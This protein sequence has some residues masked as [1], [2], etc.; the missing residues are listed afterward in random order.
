MRRG[1]W[2]LL[3]AAGLF[4]AVGCEEEEGD[5][6]DTVV[7]EGTPP[8]IIHEP[9]AD[10]Q[11]AFVQV[12][13]E[14][15]VTDDTGVSA[16]SLFY[17]QGGQLDWQISYLSPTGEP[18]AYA[19]TLAAT[20]V[21]ATGVD[22]YIRAVDDA[23]PQAEAFSPNGAP[24]EFHHFDV[25]V[26]GETLPFFEDWEDGAD[27]IDL[28]WLHVE[29]GMGDYH[30]EL[31][32]LYASSGGVSVMHKE[33][34]NGVPMFKD[35][36]ISP[37]LEFDGATDMAVNWYELGLYTSDMELHQ[38]Y[39]S[40]GSDDPDLGDFQLVTDL[41]APLEE[42]WAP[43]EVIDITDLVG[44]GGVGYVAFYYEGEYPAD[45]WFVDD[46][47][48]GEP[49]P[50]FVIDEITV[51]P[52][53]FE[54]GD[55]LDITISVTNLALV[56]SEPVTGSL[57]SDDAL[58]VQTGDDVD[59]GAVASGAT[60][61]GDGA[62]ELTIDAEH[63]DNAYLD[64]ALRLTDG[65]HIWDL[66]FEL[67]MGEESYA[68]VD[69]DATT[70]GDVILTVGYGDPDF[71][72]FEV[73]T[74]VE[75]TSQWST[76]LTS[77]ADYLPP[78]VG[79]DRWW[80]KITN[81]G[82]YPTSVS[83]FEI[84]WGGEVFTCEELPATVLAQSEGVVYLPSLP[85]LEVGGAITSPDPVAPGDAAVE[86]TLRVDNVGAVATAGA[87]TGTLTSTDPHVSNITGAGITFGVDPLEPGQVVLSDTLFTFDVDAAH[88]DDSDL[89]LIL[90]LTDGVD[91]FELDVAVPVPH[92]HGVLEQ[93][94]VDDSD[95]NDDGV[96]DRGENV[97]VS[98]VLRNAGD[99][100]ILDDLT[101]TITPS[102]SSE[103]TLTITDG[104][105][106]LAG[107]L[108]AG[109]SQLLAD[110]F[111]LSADDGY[112]GDLVVLDAEITDGTDTWTQT[113]EMEL[114]A[115][116][117]SAIAD[118]DD[119]MGD[120]N[121]YMFDIAQ[122]W[123]KTDGEVMWIKTD[124]H[125]PFDE[126]TLWMTYA[127][128]DVPNWWRLEFHYAFGGFRVMDGWFDGW[129][130]GD[131][132]TPTLPILYRTE[133]EGGTYSLLFRFLLEDLEVDGHSLRLGMHA[134]SCPF[135]YYC[136]T[137]EDNWFYLDLKNA[138]YG[139]SDELL[140]IFAW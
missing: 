117:W 119:A 43:S 130:D 19:G 46:V 2:A 5:D 113:F 89:S 95:G 121:G 20:V 111:E 67:L 22:Y 18:G 21:T 57:V 134:G 39:V 16:V 82:L 84:Q 28:D 78:E 87:L 138:Q 36:L 91:T 33:G 26:V 52:E 30:W 23:I 66:P 58:L 114:S 137:A 96:L 105:E 118:A 35:W 125:T 34:I 99:H 77:E 65:D 81:D 56:D 115:R 80:L 24:D 102:A 54:P 14:C 50:D 108:F 101:V 60:A 42:Q 79:E 93:L 139:Q 9:V 112:M 90:E 124:S 128:Y 15:I 61:Y 70:S 59:Y 109:Q 110:A 127:F 47:Y 85:V 49:M 123:F 63:A 48:V 140:Y 44:E 94:V 116:A 69:Y 83:G 86:L 4:L 38:L 31:S 107:G 126:T 135:V 17:R 103:V 27:L 120:A 98:A 64:L 104:T 71:P 100:D 55:V 133:Q 122:T 8:E 32:D 136:D 51:A 106:T 41:T 29:Q 72:T 73:S 11:M 62:L 92:A 97:I 12:S 10:G 40:M 131:E 129:F 76:T 37:P 7:D 3:A 13:V 53:T 88:V 75:D 74:D 6:D 68:V 132:V 45:K 1:L 25:Q